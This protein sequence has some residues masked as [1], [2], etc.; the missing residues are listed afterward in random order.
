MN[1]QPPV[2]S[3][4]QEFLAL[5]VHRGFLV[6]EEAI[7]VLKA[8]A[9]IGLSD[10][11]E[12][13]F[14]WD[15]KRQAFLRRTQ[16]LSK[17]EIPGYQ[18]EST[19]GVGGTSEVF[20]ARRAKDFQKVALKIL[21]PMLA[22][23]EA[24]VKRFLEEAKV[25]AKLEHPF[26]VRGH[27]V[28][29]FVGTFVLEMEYV[30]GQTLEEYLDEGRTFA[31]GEALDIIVQVARV[32]E[33]MREQGIL[34]RDLKPGNLMLNKHG[35][36]KVIDLGFAG[37]GMS[38]RATA[39]TTMGTP[40]YLSPE[41]ARGEDDLDVRADIYSLGATL[42]HLV[43]GRLPFEGQDDADIMRKQVLAGLSGSALKGRQVSPY[44]HYFI[45][46]MMA[47]DREVRYATPADLADDIEAHRRRQED[48]D[49]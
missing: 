1:A 8:A 6:K 18:V 45:E 30:S 48:L 20:L 43:L 26:I 44:L 22:R 31:E 3:E 15:S 12:G 16:G 46:K 47:K 36:L 38:G 13:A 49:T 35:K 9:E 28:F 32:L 39:G 34:H 29:K 25:L 27:R 41:Q 14:G 40:A 10:A 37:E 24:A 21:R 23:D 42:Y 5:L 7:E 2:S 19:L 17:P 11:L 4:D 33:Y